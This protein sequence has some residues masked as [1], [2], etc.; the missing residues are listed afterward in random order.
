MHKFNMEL[1]LNHISPLSKSVI[2]FLIFISTKK[3]VQK[4]IIFGS[5]AIGDYEEYSDLD[6]AIEAPSLDKMEWLKLREYSIYDLKTLIRISIVN[7][8]TNPQK[9]KERINL[10]GKTIYEQHSK[11]KR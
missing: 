5:R 1:Q 10:T 6:L 8:S 4:M 11:I 7:F 2:D 3:E 9:L